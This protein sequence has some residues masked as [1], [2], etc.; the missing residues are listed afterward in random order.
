MSRTTVLRACALVALAT[1]FLACSDEPVTA[2]AGPTLFEVQLDESRSHLNV[3]VFPALKEGE[4]LH[5]RIRQGAGG[6]LDCASMANEI[7]RID[8][9]LIELPTDTCSKGRTRPP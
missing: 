1:G 2:P 8:A 5:V 3:T 4:T 6:V 7:E 9:Q